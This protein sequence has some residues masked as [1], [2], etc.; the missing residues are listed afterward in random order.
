MPDSSTCRG[1]FIDG[2]AADRRGDLSGASTK[3][4]P[5]VG[6]SSLLAQLDSAI[7]QNPLN[8]SRE[9]LLP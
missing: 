2:C 8:E 3:S 6:S 5:L 1:G 4:E 9:S 7:W